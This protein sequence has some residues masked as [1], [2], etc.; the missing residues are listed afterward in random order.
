[1]SLYNETNGRAIL[2]TPTIGGVGVLEDFR[3]QATLAFK[4]EG[5]AILLI[6]E[7]KGWL[8]QSCFLATVL[9]REDGAPPPVDLMAEKVNGD[10]VRTLI[11][12]EMATAVHD[13]SD[14]G[15]LVAIAE[16]AMASGIGAT[17]KAMPGLPSHAFWFGEDQ[18][19]YLVAAPAGRVADVE[20]LA[21]K[22]GIPLTQLGSTGGDRLTVPGEDPILVSALHALH[23]SWLPAYMA[24]GP[25]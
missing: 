22:R 16:M 8:G 13:L 21:T 10:F 4:A 20:A 6:G 18:A 15:L 24:G 2:P 9:G 14:G 5:D 3:K 11:D 23:E 1:V 17:L 12:A 19:R 25:G 7:T